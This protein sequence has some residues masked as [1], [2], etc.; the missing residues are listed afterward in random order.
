MQLL[1]LKNGEPFSSSGGSLAVKGDASD[2]TFVC[3][4]LASKELFPKVISIVI[5]MLPCCKTNTVV[6]HGLS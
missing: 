4:V 3:V 6:A 2:V 1:N 5:F